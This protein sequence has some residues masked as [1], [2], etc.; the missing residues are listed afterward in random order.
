MKSR[1]C[2]E[3]HMMACKL[4]ISLLSEI[5]RIEIE[6]EI[7]LSCFPV[8]VGMFLVDRIFL[9]VWP[10]KPGYWGWDN[11]AL[12][13]HNTGTKSSCNGPEKETAGLIKCSSKSSALFFWRRG[14]SQGLR[15]VTKDGDLVN[16]LSQKILHFSC[17]LQWMLILIVDVL[18]GG[19]SSDPSSCFQLAACQPRHK[20]YASSIKL[21]KLD[22]VY[23]VNI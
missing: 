8:Y 14:V 12:K 10:I 5:D 2:T 18:D 9:L 1:L 15:D 20:P 7:E 16:K 21:A 11:T 6:E 19:L 3:T 13:L 4:L 22:N 17:D 23:N